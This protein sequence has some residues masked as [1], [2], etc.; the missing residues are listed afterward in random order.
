[1]HISSQLLPHFVLNRSITYWQKGGAVF[2]NT[3]KYLIMFFANYLITLSVTTV[4]VE[5]LR[6]KPYFGIILSTFATAFSSFLLMKHFVFV[7]EE[8][9]K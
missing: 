2:H 5:L 6:L 9:I 4:T 7:R 3:T 1:V 8:N